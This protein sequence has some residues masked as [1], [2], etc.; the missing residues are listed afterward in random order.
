MKKIGKVLKKSKRKIVNYV[1]TNRLFLSYVIFS[2]I[3]T[4]LIR[5]FTIKNTFDIVPLLIDTGVILAIGALGYLIKPKNQF[6]Y[7]FTWI[8]RGCI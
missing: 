3:S 6:K 7:Y 2:I 4:I 5:N 8:I 1:S